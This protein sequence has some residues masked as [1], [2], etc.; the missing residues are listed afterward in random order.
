MATADDS[1]ALYRFFVRDKLDPEHPETPRPI[2]A[3]RFHLTSDEAD[4]RF[5]VIECMEHTRLPQQ[6]SAELRRSMF[7]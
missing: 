7:D 6:I 2:F 5:E 3:T 1:N 4:K